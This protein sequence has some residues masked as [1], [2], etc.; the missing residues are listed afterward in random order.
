MK[1]PLIKRLPREI[2]SELG[3]FIALFLFLTSTIGFVSGFLVADDS[4]KITY[5]Q[6]FEKYNTENGHFITPFKL[7]SETIDELEKEDLKLHPIFYKEFEGGEGNKY[8]IYKNRN[9]VNLPCVME[10][11]LPK[12]SDEIAID[13]LYAENNHIEIG[14]RVSFKKIEYK[15][16]GFIALPDYSALFQESRE[17]M[18]NAKNFTVA[19]VTNKGFNRLDDKNLFYA[20]AWKYNREGLSDKEQNK[21]AEAFKDVLKGK[22]PIKDFSPRQDNEAIKFA[23]NDMGRDKTM[24]ETILYI[25]ILVM[26]FAFSVTQKNTVE[27]EASVIGTLRASGYTKAQLIVHY[28]SM[29][30]IIML[31]ASLIG[32]IIGYTYM[33]K[34]IAGLYYHSYSLPTYET[35]FNKDAFIMTTVIPILIVLAVNLIGLIRAFRVSP[36]NFLRHELKGQKNRKAM[37]LPDW[38]I[39]RKFRFRVIS[40]NKGIYITM[41][42]GVLMTAIM[43]IFG[44]MLYPLLDNYS[45]NVV[46]SKMAEYQYILKAPV[47]T[48][49]KG[50]EKYA[51]TQLENL[52]EESVNVIGILPDSKYVSFKGEIVQ[53]LG[54][55][56]DEGNK[57][58]D[59]LSDDYIIVSDGYMEKYSLKPG[60]QVELRER[61]GNRKF[62]FKIAGSHVYPASFTMYLSL[63]NFNKIFDMEEDYFNG[64]LSDKKLKDIDDGFVMS[65]ITEKELKALSDQLYDS[66][67][68][69]FQ[70][71]AVFSLFMYILI[72]YLLSKLIVEKNTVSISML[73][74][75]G[76]TDK[77]ASRI[78]NMA[79]AI[80]VVFSLIVTLPLA[81][82]MT[83]AIYFSR[84]QDFNGWLPFH[85]THKIDVMVL[86]SGLICFMVVYLIEKSKIKKIH[87]SEALKSME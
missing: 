50:A 16:S 45:E 8:R 41:F 58:I 74:I 4:M 75:L 46:K 25:V 20:Y 85:M 87:L 29:P 27:K 66:M 72:M 65:I 1:N 24:I 37:K 49:V 38:H 69:V 31:V 7:S 43:L 79:T 21:K 64:Y 57:D 17:F 32:N 59:K 56:E 2:R 70:L 86:V 76:Y 68:N 82:Q 60:D 61:Y 67:G 62:K 71:F 6:G 48:R 18:F 34:V 15:V 78:Y 28:M 14:D 23:G 77:E 22:T 47:E 63:K 33:K 55:S 51:V 10:G 54:S 30:I 19:L 5:D 84:M 42:I 39:I 40:Q 80:V 44:T 53:G 36:L 26:A 83:K 12:Q 73:K 35:H 3:K 11:R 13:R 52:K 81:K 9:T